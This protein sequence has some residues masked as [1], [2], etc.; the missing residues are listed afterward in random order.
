MA[1]TIA[2]VE[3]YLVEL[4]RET[5][6]RTLR[7]VEGVPAQ[8]D[9][10]ELTRILNQAPAAYV[11]FLG[12]SD[13]RSSWGVYAVSTHAGGQG[14][15]RHGD[16]RAIGAFEIAETVFRRLRDHVVPDVGTISPRSIENLFGEAFAKHGRAVY[17]VV[18]DLP[19]EFDRLAAEDLADFVTFAADWDVPPHGHV[20]PPLPAASAD[21][22]D[23]VHLET[24]Q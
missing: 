12:W 16:A 21:A 11:A 18:L 15:A 6:G 2:A 3:L 5:F 4:L 17:G 24:E 1:S 10:A 8:L 9:A 23:L 7:A 14:S 19:M 20:Q 13:G 22:R